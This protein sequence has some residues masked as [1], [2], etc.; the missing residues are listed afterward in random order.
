MWGNQPSPVVYL[1]LMNSL[2]ALE[3][4]VR[5]RKIDRLD[6]GT[7]ALQL[8][9]QY[10]NTDPFCIKLGLT[11]LVASIVIAMHDTSQG[12]KPALLFGRKR[13]QTGGAPSHLAEA[14]LRAQIVLM[15]GMLSHAGVEGREA[16]GWLARELNKSGVMQKKT[17]T[18]PNGQPIGPRQIVRW[19]G[20][21]RGKSISGSDKIYQRL[22]REALA[23]QSWPLQSNEARRRVRNLIHAL[24]AAGF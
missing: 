16:S 2:F 12:A 24:R 15:F 11:K 3:V 19:S 5:N 17:K 6:A 20:E 7:R 14:G 22:E 9:L 8:V 23:R 4:G 10:F 1:N 13:S 21:L 18:H